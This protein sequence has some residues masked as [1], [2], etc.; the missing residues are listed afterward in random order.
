[1]QK[2]DFVRI[3]DL[4]LKV[5]FPEVDAVVGIREGGVVPAALIGYKLAK[6]VYF[7]GINYRDINNVPCR[8]RPEL[9]QS[10]VLPDGVNRILLVDDV[11]VSGQTLRSAAALLAPRQVITFVLK[12]KADLVLITDIQGCVDWP[13]KRLIRGEDNQCTG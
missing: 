8:Q 7:V 4:L 13:W 10:L 5:D 12:G 11:S 3:M 2:I 9:L 6:P 1:M